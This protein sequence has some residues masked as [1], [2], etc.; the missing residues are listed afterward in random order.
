MFKRWFNVDFWMKDSECFALALD[1]SG[2]QVDSI[3]SNIGHLLW[4]GIVDDDKVEAVVNHLMGPALF[5]GWGIRT[6]ATTEGGYNPIGY[7]V[8]TVWPF[9]CSIVALG[10]NRYGYREESSR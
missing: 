2:K 1:G 7:H 6:M 3:T 8:G 9:D 10:L 4:S 5:S